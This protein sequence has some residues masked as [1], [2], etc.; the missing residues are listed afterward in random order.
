MLEG[1]FEGVFAELVETVAGP[2]MAGL[3]SYCLVADIDAGSEAGEIDV[4]PVG[5]LGQGIEVAAV[6]YYVGIDGV[7]E[8]IGETGLIEC[9][10]LVLGEVDLEIASSFGGI[11]A[12]AGQE[13]DQEQKG[14]AGMERHWFF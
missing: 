5:V 14:G 2:A 11:Y 7:F 13:E 1:H 12:I 9:L 6:P 10:I 8:G 4:Y 3:G